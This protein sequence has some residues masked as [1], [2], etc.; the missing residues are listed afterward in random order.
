VKI[1][2]ESYPP[3]LRQ[4]LVIFLTGLYN[5]GGDTIARALQTALNEQGGR[6]VS[7]LLGDLVDRNFKPDS[8][9]SREERYN[10]LQRMAFVASE[11]ARAGAAVIASTTAPHEAGR[12]AVR[13]T[14]TRQAGPGGNFFLI[15]VATPIEHCVKTDRRGVYVRA[16]K[17]IIK[18]FVGVDEEFDPPKDPNLVV[19]I[20][21]Q[22]IPEIV[23]S[24]VLLLETTALL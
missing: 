15:H 1:L 2:R 19:D 24:I 7:L 6:S 14:I 18:G 11:L 3:R 5:S 20:T 13:E 17:G 12:Q 4:G 16:R 22:S 9:L 10:H 21:R 23:H 8:T